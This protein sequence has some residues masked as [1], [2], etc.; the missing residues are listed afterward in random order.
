MKIDKEFLG[1]LFEQAVCSPQLCADCTLGS[2]EGDDFQMLR[3][4]LP[5]MKEDKQRHPTPLNILCLCGTLYIV[6]YKEVKEHVTIAEGFDRGMDAQDVM[7]KMVLVESDHIH[8]CPA[9]AEY[10]C[11]IPANT[12]YSIVVYDPSVIYLAN[13]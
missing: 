10:G 8:V 9:T 1:K 12:W 3:A 4:V 7:C 5:G 13:E 6:L 2:A 11:T